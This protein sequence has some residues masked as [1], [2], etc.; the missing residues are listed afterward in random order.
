MV[1]AKKKERAK[2]LK[3]VK[4]L[5]KKFSFTAGIQ[6]ETLTTVSKSL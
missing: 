2:A 6:N 3:E 1:K 5:C 4:R